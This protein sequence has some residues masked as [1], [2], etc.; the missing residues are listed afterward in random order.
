M[1][2]ANKNLISDIRVDFI[3]PETL[4]SEVKIGT[5]IISTLYYDHKGKG[6]YLYRDWEDR[7]ENYIDFET[8]LE[9][10]TT[11]FIAQ[12]KPSNKTKE[13]ETVLLYNV[14]RRS[15]S[16]ILVTEENKEYLKLLEVSEDEDFKLFRTEETFH[17][18]L[19]N[20]KLLSVKDVINIIITTST[21]SNIDLK[22][23]FRIL[24]HNLCQ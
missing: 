4:Q 15:V 24:K 2:T 22:E 11:N 14:V 9:D 13:E 1:V 17:S 8:F 10:S 7:E 18:Y 16:R 20:E 3:Y 21:L 5:T 12:F 23:I 19:E 6:K